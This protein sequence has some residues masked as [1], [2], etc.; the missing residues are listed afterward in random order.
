M[1]G[2]LA[3]E[4]IEAHTTNGGGRRLGT[5]CSSAA[6]SRVRCGRT[7]GLSSPSPKTAPV[8]DRFA[9]CGGPRAAVPGELGG[10]APPA[11]GRWKVGGGEAGPI[12]GGKDKGKGKDKRQ[13]NGSQARGEEAP[14]RLL[15]SARMPGFR[16][17]TPEPTGAV[18]E[19]RA[20]WAVAMAELDLIESAIRPVPRHGARLPKRG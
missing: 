5:C 17:G 7:G 3:A 20:A 19:A 16:T 6:A 12:G 8:V 15:G 18:T 11:M 4:P 1:Y 2:L 10:L 13:G 14:G 9:E